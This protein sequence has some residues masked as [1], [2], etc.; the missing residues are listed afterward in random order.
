M[1][2]SSVWLRFGQG[3]AEL[4]PLS[5]SSVPPLCQKVRPNFSQTESSVYQYRRSDG[6]KAGW[7]D[8][9]MN[10]IN[11]IGVATAIPATPLTTPLY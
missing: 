5:V 2:K 7:P 9:L 3:S 10:I 8:I 1:T 6:Q 11:N 4:Y